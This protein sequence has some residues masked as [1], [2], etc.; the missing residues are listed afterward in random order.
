MPL[1]EIQ[2]AE[3]MLA[4]RPRD[5]APHET[6][7][8][9]EMQAEIVHAMLEK[10]YRAQLDQPVPALGDVSPREAARTAPGRRKLVAWLKYLENGTAGQ[11]AAGDPMGDYDFG[12]MWAELGVKAL[13][14]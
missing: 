12:W 5:A 8:P 14:K 7:I 11:K 3:Q 9:P 2:T 13:R 6:T 10:H 1:T 4:A